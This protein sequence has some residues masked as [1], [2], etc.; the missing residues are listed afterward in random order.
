M[1]ETAFIAIITVLI[2]LTSCKKD[3][4]IKS[5]DLKPN[6]SGVHDTIKPLDYFPAFPGSY[7]IYD[8]YD[9]LK[10]ADQYEKYIFN[11]AEYSAVP[12]YDTLYLPKLIL[13][14]V[15]NPTD[16]FAFVREYSISKAGKSDYRAPSFKYIISEYEDST[17]IIG[18][19]IENHQ[20]MG[21]TIKTDTSVTVGTKT[22]DD[23]LIT[24]E[25]DIACNEQG[26]YPIDSCAYKR[27]FYANGVGLIKRE[28]GGYIPNENWI[29]D[30]ELKNYHINE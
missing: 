19:R 1:R 27:E 10:V 6:V 4:E 2:A 12:D 15:Y 22:Y 17:F 30:F 25:L 9:T 13:N 7:W 16:T 5:D 18:G 29:T 24:I 14:G 28:S 8:N 26:G 3:D 11:S 20:I 21:K 23:V